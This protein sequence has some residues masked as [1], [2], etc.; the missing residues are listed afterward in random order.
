MQVLLLWRDC[1]AQRIVKF[2]VEYSIA[3]NNLSVFDVKPIEVTLLDSQCSTA[4]TKMAVRAP[5]FYQLLR[6]RFLASDDLSLLVDEIAR[7]HH[8]AVVT[9]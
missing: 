8:L 2:V 6:S 5:K 3:G 9:G 1:S 7:L 4:V